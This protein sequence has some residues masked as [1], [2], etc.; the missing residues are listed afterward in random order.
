VPDEVDVCS[1]EP[2]DVDGFEDADGCPDDNDRDGLADAED[3]CPNEAEVVNG[4]AD[5]DGCPDSDQVRVVGDTILLDERVHFWINSFVIRRTSYPLLE[6]VAQL[7]NDHPEYLLVEVR[8]HSDGRGDPGFNERLSQ[9]RAR[10]V[11]QF[12]IEHGGVDGDRLT[13]VG[14]GSS[15]PLTNERDDRAMFLNRRVEFGVTRGQSTS[16]RGLPTQTNEPDA[17]E[18]P[19]PATEPPP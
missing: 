3:Q 17:P 15:Q 4:Y 7:L 18:P 14:L 8:G 6:R 19:L 2:E 13:A 12:L 11:V 10:A 16:I 1:D 5:E 9:E